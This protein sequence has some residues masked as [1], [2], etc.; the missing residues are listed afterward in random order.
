M[1]IPSI[2]G[3]PVALCLLMTAQKQCWYMH[4]TRRA[5]ISN[6]GAASCTRKLALVHPGKWFAAFSEIEMHNHLSEFLPL[7]ST[8]VVPWILDK[9][10]YHVYTLI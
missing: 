9:F 1:V 10:S 4:K 6:I 5:S 8:P 3:L 7:L 2:P